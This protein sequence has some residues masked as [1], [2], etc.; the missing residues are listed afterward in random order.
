MKFISEMSIKV[1]CLL[2]E[3]IKNFDCFVEEHFK[4]RSY[5]EGGFQQLPV[6]KK[7]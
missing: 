5:L 6:Q 2:K 3:I 4:K 1:W 7:N